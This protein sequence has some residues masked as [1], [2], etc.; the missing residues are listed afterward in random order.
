ML[1]QPLSVMRFSAVQRHDHILFTACIHMPVPMNTD[2]ESIRYIR[3][4]QLIAHS[5]EAFFVTLI[6][7]IPEEISV[8]LLPTVR[9]GNFRTMRG[10]YFD[11]PQGA[12]RVHFR[13]CHLRH[14]PF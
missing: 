11:M 7:S 14:R 8:Q 6:H 9:A 4:E 2:Q 10:K 1:S 3:Q 13:D 5:V 12:C